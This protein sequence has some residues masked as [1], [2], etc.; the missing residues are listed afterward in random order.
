MDREWAVTESLF[1]DQF[2]RTLGRFVISLT[3]FLF[4]SKS[5]VNPFEWFAINISAILLR[6]VARFFPIIHNFC[7]ETLAHPCGHGRIQP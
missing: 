5:A 1:A 3:S 2:R 4:A 7:L 6:L